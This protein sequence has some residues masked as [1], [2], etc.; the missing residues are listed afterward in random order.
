[1][2][3]RVQAFAFALSGNFERCVRREIGRRDLTIEC[4]RHGI[5]IARGLLGPTVAALY[6][7]ARLALGK[8]PGR[9]QSARALFRAASGDRETCVRGKPLKIPIAGHALNERIPA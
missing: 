8:E 4:H 2:W 1:M 5:L 3:Q 9:V 6:Q 7:A